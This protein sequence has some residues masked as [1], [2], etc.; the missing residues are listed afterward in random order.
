MGIKPETIENVLKEHG[1]AKAVVVTNPTFY[2][3]VLTWR[4]LQKSYMN[5]E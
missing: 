1:D 4:G 3:Y 2:G 5:E